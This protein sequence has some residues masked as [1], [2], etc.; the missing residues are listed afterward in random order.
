MRFAW[1]AE[2]PFNF[3]KDGSLTGCDVELARYVSSRLGETFEPVET[4]FSD[5]LDGLADGRWDVTTGM[6][7]TPERMARASFTMP[8][9]SLRDGL[10]IR[11][12]DVGMIE[13]YQDIARHGFKLA[14]LEGQIQHRTALDLGVPEAAIVVLQSYEEAAE[15]VATGSARAYASVELAHRSH[16][17]HSDAFSCVPVP[18]EEKAAAD[19]GFACRNAAICDRLNPVLADFIGGDDHAA[20][21]RSFGLDPEALPASR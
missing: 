4:E 6:F 7:L 10:L 13:G 2:P 8:I 12:D 5:L 15:A 1:I 14:V 3:R 21:L 19:G 16:V 20:L 11:R 17:E 18:V 9:W